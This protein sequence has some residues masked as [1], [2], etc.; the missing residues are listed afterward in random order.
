MTRFPY[1]HETCPNCLHPE[2][3]ETKG[4]VCQ[5]CGHDYASSAPVLGASLGV[6]MEEATAAA[7]A[8]GRILSAE[9]PDTTT[10]D[11]PE[12][13]SLPDEL[14]PREQAMV[15]VHVALGEFNASRDDGDPEARIPI[16]L[17]ETIVDAVLS[18]APAQLVTE[19]TSDG[20]HTFAELYEHRHALWCAFAA[21][22]LRGHG[23]GMVAWKSRAHHPADQPIYPGHFIAG[24]DLPGCGQV[25]YHLP[26]CWWDACPGHVAPHAPAWDHHSPS[27]VVSRLTAF[28]AL[29][30][31]AA[32]PDRGFRPIPE[33]ARDDGARALAAGWPWDDNTQCATP[34]DEHEHEDCCPLAWWPDRSAVA[35]AVVRGLLESGWTLT[36]PGERGATR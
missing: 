1:D 8:A 4:M 36:P 6:T 32:S 14:T 26:E 25:S 2:A 35:A 12:L 31:Q 34:Y 22:M 18:T 19:D 16:P 30:A 9:A 21:H 7:H 29:T 15:A 23:R 33:R 28:A 17:R 24:V 3:R 20:C 5:S 11:Q 27:D 13:E 10:Q